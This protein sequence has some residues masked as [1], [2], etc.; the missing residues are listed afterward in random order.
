MNKERILL[1]TGNQ[2]KVAEFQSLLGG[3]PVQILSLKEMGREF[4]VEEDGI[5]FRENAIK[6]ARAA[7]EHFSCLTVADDSGL[8]VDALNGAPGVQSARFAGTQG[9]DEAN[10]DKL[11]R[12]LLDV[13]WEKRTARFRCSIAVAL[14]TGETYTTDG[15]CEGLIGYERRGSNG[16]GYDPLFHVPEYQKT[17]AELDMETKNQIS[18]RARA[19]LGARDILR[20]LL[21]GAPESLEE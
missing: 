3:L 16:F 18:H 9:D 10:N 19:F 8:E 5:T 6:K 7:A 4:A 20:A 17:F 14:P 21:E 13:P 11:L 1:A 2:G 12:L 15:V